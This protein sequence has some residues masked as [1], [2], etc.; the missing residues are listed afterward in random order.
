MK[1]QSKCPT[2]PL[3]PE[4]RSDEARDFQ[5]AL[6]SRIVGQDAA[7][8]LIV[9]AY[10][11]YL[12][13]LDPQ[14]RPMGIFLFLGPTGTGKTRVVE[15]AA[16]ILFGTPR[17]LL[18]IDCAEFQHSHEIAK[19][20]GSPPGYIGHRETNPALTQEALEQHQT[21]RTKFALVL[22]DEIEKASD[23]LWKLL[24][25]IL[26][27]AVLTL[28][29][30]R[31][32]DFSRT[33]IFTSSNLGA[34]EMTACLERRIG[35]APSKPGGVMEQEIERIAIEA[36]R[37]NFSPEFINRID[38][39]VVFK[40]L[41]AAELERILDI[42]LDGLQRRLLETLPFALVFSDAARAFLLSHGTDAS[43]GAR[44][45]KRALDRYVIGPLASLLASRQ[46]ASGD[47]VQVDIASG[48][49]TLLFLHVC[50]PTPPEISQRQH[51]ALS[52]K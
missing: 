16:E 31:T 37:R 30:N 52:A 24:L 35:F 7:V 27:K 1:T 44:P 48:R 43:Y 32:V 29:D 26:D 17:A 2:R 33:M 23:A 50:D 15:A 18:K 28:G 22:F 38:K 21:D 49:E 13:G 51:V 41:S 39:M 40:P 8:E 11:R 45:L 46:I 42:E 5:Q 47:I 14:G 10:Q 3:Y 34:A 36:A 4:H 12:A 9:D 19:L 20:V 25:G 6:R